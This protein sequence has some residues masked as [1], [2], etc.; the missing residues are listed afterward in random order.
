MSHTLGKPGA[1][2][3]VQDYAVVFGFGIDDIIGAAFT[4]CHN[5][6]EVHS[7]FA[8][9]ATGFSACHNKRQ[10]EARILDQRVATGVAH[11]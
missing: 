1:A 2:G 6:A 4:G 5:I 11:Q 7:V 3:G 9:L 10:I 8:E